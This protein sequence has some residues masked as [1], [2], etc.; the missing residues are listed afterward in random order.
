MIKT[1]LY[2]Y[3]KA[4]RIWVPLAGSNITSGV[5]RK[6]KVIDLNDHCRLILS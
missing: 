5:T 6:V 3:D 2:V 4:A 1:V